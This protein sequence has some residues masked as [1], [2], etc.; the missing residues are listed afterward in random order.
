MALDTSTVALS[1]FGSGSSSQA[2]ATG[3]A[4]LNKTYQQILTTGTGA[5]QADRIYYTQPTI[6]ASG[7]TTIDLAGS[8]TDIFGA[9]I[10]FARVKGMF[11]AASSANTNNVVVGNSATNGFITWVGGATH[12]VT[13]RPGGFLALLAPDAT[14]YAVT[15]G[16]GDLLMFTNS[17][18]GTS[19]TFDA[20]FIGSSV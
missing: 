5:N 14:A 20:I 15:A 8:V 12:T 1:V 19:V 4:Q 6:A 3:V 11:I 16:T 18:A 7:T 10:T 13:V 17:G 9:T 2:L